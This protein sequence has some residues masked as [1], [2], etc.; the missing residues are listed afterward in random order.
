M[1][2]YI[3]EQGAV[4]SKTGDSL[5]IKKHRELVNEFELKNIE[6]IQMF[7]TIHIT[8]PLVKNLLRRGIELAYY[9]M[10]GELIGQLTPVFSK[11]IELRM[12]Q[13]NGHRDTAFKTA[14]IEKILD[15]RVQTCIDLVEEF[16]K[17]RRQDDLAPDLAQLRRYREIHESLEEASVN[18]T[19]GIEGSFTRQYFQIYKKLLIESDLFQ[20]RS[21]RPPK[22]P[23][24]ATLSFLYVLLTNKLASM[25]DGVGFDPYLGFYHGVHYGRVSL[26]CD[27][28]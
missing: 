17:N 4:L 1:E 5:L 6:S 8:T 28:L 21:R 3:T 10:T 13:H 26:A 18:Q 14:L 25:L 9:R 27:L 20:G 11:N 16:N 7:G 24:N 2:I 23:V 15:A 22:D 12:K 19:M